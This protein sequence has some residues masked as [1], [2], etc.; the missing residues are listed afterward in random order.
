MR[1]EFSNTPLAEIVA[2]FNHQ[3]RVQ[4]GLGPDDLGEMRISGV[5]WADDPEGFSRLIEVSA[6]LRVER[7]TDGRITLRR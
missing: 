5:F 2:L 4:L 6:G 1:V 3:N 7:S